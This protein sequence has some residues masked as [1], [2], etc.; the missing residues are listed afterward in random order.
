MSRDRV[1]GPRG[2]GAELRHSAGF[3]PGDLAGGLRGPLPGLGGSDL[4]PGLARLGGEFPPPGGA[5]ANPRPL[6]RGRGGSSGRRR[7]DGGALGTA[8]SGS[9]A[10][11][12][13]FD[14]A[15]PPGGY[16]WWYVDAI[17]SDRRFGLTLI[18]FIGSVFS[19]YYHWS[20]RTDPENHVALNV[21][22]YGVR[23]GWAMT[24][25]S[26]SALARG[27]D[28]LA[29]GRSTLA[30]D[31]EALAVDIRETSFP[32]P[33]RFRGRV[34]VRPRALVMVPFAL[35]RE[36]RHLW[37]PVATR[38]DV[39]VRMARPEL[40]WRGEGYFDSNF[41]V[42]P[43]EEAFALWHWSRAHLARSEVVLYE[44]T[45]RDG[46]RFALGLG[47]DRAGGVHEVPLPPEVVLPRTLWR[48][49]R[50]T[51]ADAGAAVR[52]RRTWEDTPFYARSA[53][54]TQLFGETGDA[55]H[56]SLSL[57]RLRRPVVKLMLPFRMPRVIGP[58]A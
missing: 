50:V 58:A 36:R 5:D 16:A 23:P 51:R 24:E 1:S 56:E 31:G 43:L 22:L 15:V 41:G 13:G 17:S 26:R 20:G 29:I 9:P 55:V 46:S 38:A 37:Q 4:R 42:E 53:L 21:A 48:M 54:E 25:R 57:D 6:S 28:W 10:Q 44:G 40:A 30:W 35:D 2:P 12:P 52:V 39:E 18:A 27:A 49:P 32:L 33:S 3:A 47:F 8:G 19:P 7:A 45:R 11:G 34:T 14:A